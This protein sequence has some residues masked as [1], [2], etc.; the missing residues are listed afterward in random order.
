[1]L[2]DPSDEGPAEVN[3][4]KGWVILAIGAAIFLVFWIGFSMGMYLYSMH[5]AESIL[6]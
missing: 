1:M 3:E 6:Q 5:T 2:R 4:R